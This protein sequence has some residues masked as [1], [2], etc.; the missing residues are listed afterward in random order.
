MDVA[1]LEQGLAKRERS[2][3]FGSNASRR[4]RGSGGLIRKMG[5]SKSTDFDLFGDTL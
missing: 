5:S 1:A 3:S 2:S 4:K